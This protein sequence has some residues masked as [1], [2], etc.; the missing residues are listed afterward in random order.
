MNAKWINIPVPVDNVS[1]V[2]NKIY[3][4][5]GVV[6]KEKDLLIAGVVINGKTIMFDEPR[7]FI[8]R[9]VRCGHYILERNNQ[10]IIGS[11]IGSR[12]IL[13]IMDKA[14]TKADVMF[15]ALD[16]SKIKPTLYLE[17]MTY[18]HHRKQN[19]HTT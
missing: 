3:L 19:R 16:G 17:Y 13:T 15:I 12:Q 4:T 9:D 7:K 18:A 1:S 8:I 6:C 14:K 2:L 10:D 11:Y 5:F